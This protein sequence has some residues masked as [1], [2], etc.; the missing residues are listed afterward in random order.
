MH[1]RPLLYIRLA[2]G[3]AAG[4]P[5]QLAAQ[6]Y[7]TYCLPQSQ[8]FL[9]GVSLGD[10]AG[11]VRRILGRPVRVVRDSSEDDGGV[12]PVLHLYYR[13]L[14]VDLG[15]N[16]VELL[17]TTSPRLQLPSGIRVGMTVDEVS[18]N[19]HLPNAGQ[20]LRGDT[21]GPVLCRGGRHNPGLAGLH[22]IFG[23]STT[24]TP[25][26]VIKIVLSEYGP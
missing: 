12:Y 2:T 7:D 20:Y 1:N 11:T 22:L 18:G 17:S 5:L 26:R 8:V 24:E 19:L 23:P 4:L 10:S 6:E 14:L 25:R 15:R 9:A 13:Y 3:L 21:L 16:H